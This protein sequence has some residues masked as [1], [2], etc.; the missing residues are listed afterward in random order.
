M[1]ALTQLKTNIYF[2]FFLSSIFSLLYF[3]LTMIFLKSPTL[4]SFFLLIPFY[5]LFIEKLTLFTL[6]KLLFIKQRYRDNK[7]RA[8]FIRPL[9]L[10]FGHE[11]ASKSLSVMIEK[12]L[13]FR[14]AILSKIFDLVS[15]PL[16]LDFRQNSIYGYKAEITFL[17][18]QAV[19]SKLINGDVLRKIPNKLTFR[20]I[21]IKKRFLVTHPYTLSYNT[22][23]EY[24][25]FASLQEAI[26]YLESTFNKEFM[27]LTNFQAEVLN[28]LLSNSKN[29]HNF[30]Y[31]KLFLQ[32]Y[33]SLRYSSLSAELLCSLLKTPTMELSHLA[34]MPWG[35][36]IES[37][38]LFTSLSTRSG[39]AQ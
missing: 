34:A 12:P 21:K 36:S 15:S 16:S 1:N 6:R 33:L 31:Y 39:T 23:H 8:T 14:E 27:L 30:S 19:Y 7:V 3:S 38:E 22:Y 20:I 26:T 9:Y 2:N 32:E 24:E 5:L 35:S 13:L 10:R 25:L 37:I 18:N 29:Y 11:R 4:L 28:T 17:S